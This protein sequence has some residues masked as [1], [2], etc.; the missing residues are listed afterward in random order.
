MGLFILQ[1]LA[2]IKEEEKTDSDPPRTPPNKSQ[3]GT[4]TPLLVPLTPSL[5]VPGQLASNSTVL[6][7]IGTG[8]FVEKVSQSIF[9]SSLLPATT[10]SRHPTCLTYLLNSP[11]TLPPHNPSIQK[12]CPTWRTL[13]TI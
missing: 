11:R 4:G 2:K 13:S 8:F 12:R 5:Y 6:V 1:V 7:D 10:F 3:T 9:S